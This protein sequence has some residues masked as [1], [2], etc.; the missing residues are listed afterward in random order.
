VA[1]SVKYSRLLAFA[2]IALV[3]S[4]S[5]HFDSG[6][7]ADVG[8]PQLTAQQKKA[9]LDK[10]AGRLQGEWICLPTPGAINNCYAETLTFNPALDHLA[11]E[12]YLPQSNCRISTDYTLTTI[13]GEDSAGITEFTLHTDTMG[14]LAGASIGN[15]DC[16]SHL[17][18]FQEGPHDENFSF[19]HNAAWTQIKIGD[20]N[21]AKNPAPSPTPTSSTQPSNP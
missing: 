18:S 1:K 17:A 14:T 21:F 2:A 4:C 3:S 15:D 19:T 10:L 6:K 11:I 7:S 20:N 9:Q 8:A 16:A 12:N 5:S 13:G